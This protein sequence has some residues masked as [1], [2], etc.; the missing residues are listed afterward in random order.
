[1]QTKHLCVLVHIR[2]KG[3]V[4]T[5][6]LVKALALQ[7]FLTD[8]SKAALLLCIYYVI[9]VCLCHTV[10]SVSCSLVVTCMERADLLACI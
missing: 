8:R 4:S 7:S 10:M 6:K 3:E 5:V 2:I 9:S 1:M